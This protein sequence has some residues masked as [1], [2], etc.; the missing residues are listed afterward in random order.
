MAITRFINAA[1]A[2]GG[3]GTTNATAG[4]NRAYSSLSEAEAAEQGDLSS[5]GLVTFKCEGTTNDTAQLVISGWTNASATDYIQIEASGTGIHDGT[6]DSGYVLSRSSGHA[7]EN[8]I[9]WTR[10]GRAGFGIDIKSTSTGSSDEGIRFDLSAADLETCYV[11]GNIIRSTTSTSSKDGI[12]CNPSGGTSAITLNAYANIIYGWNR[13]GIHAQ[14]FT[15][16]NTML[17]NAIQNTMHGNGDGSSNAG[18]ILGR[19]TASGTTTIDSFNNICASVT[20]FRDQSATNTTWTGSHNVT[21]DGEFNRGSMTNGAQATDGVTTTTQAS[22][23]YIIFT[24]TTGGSEDYQLLDDS[25]GNLPVDFGTDKTATVP[26]D[27]LGNAYATTPD[28]GAFELQAGG[29]FTL[30]ADSGP[31]AYTGTDAGLLR[32]L[33]AVADSGAYLY[34][35]TNADLIQGFSLTAD[36][37]SYLYAGTNAEFQRGLVA[38]LDSGTY[39]YTG[40][41]AELLVGR[42]I[43]AES[44]SY[45]YSGTSAGLLRG[46]TLDASS[47]AYVYTGTD[48][49]LTFAPAGNFTLPADS[50]AYIYSGI[51]A[52]LL[53][54]R[55]LQANSGSY[56]YTGTAVDL[57]RGY[58]LDA[59]SGTYVYSGSAVS[60]LKASVIAAQSGTYSYNGTDITLTSSAA[61][62]TI[63]PDSATI[64]TPGVDD[65]SSW[66]TQPNSTTTWTVQ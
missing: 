24:N 39:A 17:V 55:N 41:D 45:L 37:G 33:V 58:N 22:G 56:T 21:L 11:V 59:N 29:S 31:Y 9:P 3:N 4:A 20:S 38:P 18:D 44:G 26:N 47:G 64:W 51:D 48:A 16:T 12:Y 36:S 14:N 57:K 65:A 28:N 50:G 32:A 66:T 8:D 53:V 61:I 46:F 34:T 62:W 1:A 43:A 35:G 40:A 60:L 15:G 52:Q 54:G 2:A 10:I 19:D 6:A 13:G 23:A 63:Q 49:T 7:I 27:A 30:T 42:V 25:A 5:I